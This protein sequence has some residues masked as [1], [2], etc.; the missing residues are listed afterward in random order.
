[1]TCHVHDMGYVPRPQTRV[2]SCAC[3]FMS[4]DMDSHVMARPK[5]E[6]ALLMTLR[7]HFPK[8]DM[9]RACY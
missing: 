7:R 5:I 9:L 2:K 1:M 3:H 4:H 8:N 6:H